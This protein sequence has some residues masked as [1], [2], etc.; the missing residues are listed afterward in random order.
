MTVIDSTHLK[1][2]RDEHGVGVGK[3]EEGGI[4]IRSLL[5][6]P[7]SAN[8]SRVLYRGAVE[9]KLDF[10]VRVLQRTKGMFLSADSI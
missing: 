4:G 1:N 2:G 8:H 10:W 5:K 6:V 9:T 7:N 3:A